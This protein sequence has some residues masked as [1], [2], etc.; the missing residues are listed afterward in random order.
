MDGIFKKLQTDFEFVTGY[1][2][3]GLALALG[4]IFASRLSEFTDKLDF[5]KKQAF[6]ATADKEYLY[7]DA[8]DLLP[9]NPAETAEGLIA[10][11]G[12]IGGVISAETEIIDDNGTFKVKSDATI[13]EST[14]NGVASVSNGIG[15]VTV[16]NQLTNTTALVNSV[17]KEITIVNG[18]TIQ[19]EAGDVQDA[20]AVEIKVNTAL[21][22]VVASEAGLTGNRTL[23]SALRLKLAN[24][25]VNTE[26]GAVAIIGGMDNEDVEDYRQRVIYFKSN[27]QAQ[28]SAPHI[29]AT[30]K[31]ENNTIRFAWIKGGEVVEGA[32]SAVCMNYDYG[33]TANESANALA[34]MVSIKSAPTAESALSATS[35]IV[36]G[37][38]IVIEDLVPASDGLKA[39][40]I[41]NLK[42]NFLEAKDADFYEKPITA[43]SIESIIYRTASGAEQAE[44][45]TLVNGA[46]VS[47]PN[48]FWRLGNVIF[49]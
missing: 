16:A 4:A 49:Q 47:I 44:S 42:F 30:I 11:Y 21:V 13:A 25:E 20:D 34:S 43:G 19:F 39:E 29:E 27:P 26:C 33:L 15:I 48:T 35:A 8:S 24:E 45:F 17:T 41:K 36:T 40:I 32:V 46:Q 28:F 23:N 5:I 12:Q 31:D 2:Y 6:T 37:F 22:S 10:I 38:N 18:D 1:I 3:K 14:L 9:P 7:L